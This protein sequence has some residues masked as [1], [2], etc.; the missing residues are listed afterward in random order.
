VELSDDQTGVGAVGLVAVL[1]GCLL[2][3][4]AVAPSPLYSVY[5]QQ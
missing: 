2:A 3:A 5:Q 4:A 1:L